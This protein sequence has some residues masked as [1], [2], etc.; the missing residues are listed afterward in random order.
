MFC[1]LTHK[2]LLFTVASFIFSNS[3]LADSW[4]GLR[5]SGSGTQG[6]QPLIC[7][8]GSGWQSC[9]MPVTVSLSAS[10]ASI[11]ANGQTS[12][13]TAT[14]TDYYG[15][16]V[17][18]SKVNW[19]TTNGTLSAS[20]ATTNASGQASVTL[21]SSWTL[22]G[23]SV[24]ATTAE[25]DGSNTLWVPFIDSFVSYPSAYTGWVAYGAVY[26]CTAW[27]PDPSTVATGTWFTQTATCYQNYYRYRQ[28]QQQSIVTGAVTNVGGQV[29]EYTT[30]A[31]GVSQ[32]AI[33]TK[34][35]GTCS[36]YSPIAMPGGQAA[37][38]VTIDPQ[39]AKGFITNETVMD[40]L[41]NPSS[42]AGSGPTST[43][44]HGTT[45]WNGY[46][47]WKGNRYTSGSFR[48]LNVEYG[49]IYRYYFE[50]CKSPL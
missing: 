32:G 41:L 17:A 27:T 5:T 30:S 8:N 1:Q 12:T 34:S 46:I 9:E 44:V 6:W 45:I 47:D 39:G 50:L 15:V 16:A 33:G 22:G 38:F 18:N 19:S 11:V 20:Q 23:A 35:V 29:A 7:A 2:L 25:N 3:C 48:E 24:R 4:S 28:D 36:F 21:K 31:V 37:A 14:L 40:N 10:P 26:S 42:T 13:I 49:S 43:N